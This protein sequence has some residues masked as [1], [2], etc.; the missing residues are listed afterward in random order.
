MTSAEDLWN[1]V[2]HSWAVLYM[3]ML[4]DYDW[5]VKL[6]ADSFIFANNFKAFVRDLDPARPYYTGHITYH[7]SPDLIA[8]G[9]T[10]AISRGTLAAIGPILPATPHNETKCVSKLAW[11][12]DWQFYKC[13]R[14][15]QV[16]KPYLAFDAFGRDRFFIRPITTEL[17]AY[18]DFTWLWQ[19]KPSWVGDKLRCCS[20]RPVAMHYLKVSHGL[21]WY[22]YWI[23]HFMQ[24]MQVD[25][26]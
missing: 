13:L 5:F 23:R 8:L 17:S 3:N 12:E 9:A 18:R 21:A 11:S 6:D 4:N 26:L 7:K 14:E 20:A 19:Q 25:P 15:K 22:F 10:I 2:H 16:H 24:L 1:A